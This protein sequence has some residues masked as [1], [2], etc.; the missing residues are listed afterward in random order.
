M[1]DINLKEA[2]RSKVPRRNPKRPYRHREGRFT[3]T[4]NFKSEVD[5]AIINLAGKL[6]EHFTQQAIASL[7]GTSTSTIGKMVR[8]YFAQQ[9]ESNGKA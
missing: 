4:A 3:L 6:T 2:L 5:A 7:L 8:V 9:H 1:R